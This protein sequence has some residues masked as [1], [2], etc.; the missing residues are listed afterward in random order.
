MAKFLKVP[1]STGDELFGISNIV[2]V[3][4]GDVAAPIGNLTT[5]TTIITDGIAGAQTYTFTHTAALVGGQTVL[6]A[7]NA[8]IAANPGGII[9]TLGKPIATQQV[10]A[11]QSGQ[12]GRMVVTSAPVF[13]QYASVAIA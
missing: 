11:P 1:L 12:V 5:T 3:R 4:A 6:E 8:A 13:V 10:P 2:N 7:F 9:S